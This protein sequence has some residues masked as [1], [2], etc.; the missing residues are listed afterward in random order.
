[1]RARIRGIRLNDG[2]TTA[3]TTRPAVSQS[4]SR[5]SRGTAQTWRCVQSS[6]F[7]PPPGGYFFLPFFFFFRG[8]FSLAGGLMAQ[9]G[10]KEP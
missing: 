9:A 7:H 8:F 1:M 2:L 3:S 4:R 5:P 10:T 6:V